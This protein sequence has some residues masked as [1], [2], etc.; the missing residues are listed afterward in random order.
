M[1]TGKKKNPKQNQQKNGL[2][3]EVRPRW[4]Q[5]GLESLPGW[6]D[7]YQESLGAERALFKDKTKI[8]S[9]ETSQELESQLT[10]KLTE[11]YNE[12]LI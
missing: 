8:L 9:Y 2:A 11:L 10:E 3:V 1:Q 12:E 4:N 5:E 7:I 6:K